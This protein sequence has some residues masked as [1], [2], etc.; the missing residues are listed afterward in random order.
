MS[1]LEQ[2][3]H[4]YN[5]PLVP[6]SLPNSSCSSV[7]ASSPLCRYNLGARRAVPPPTWTR[8][9]TRFLHLCLRSR[10]Q[11]RRNRL[12]SLPRYTLR[13]RSLSVLPMLLLLDIAYRRSRNA[14]TCSAVSCVAPARRRCLH[15][16]SGFKTWMADREVHCVN[17]L[18]V[19]LRAPHALVQYWLL[20]VSALQV[21]A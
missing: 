9:S 12:S 8:M 21:L 5:V 13:Q 4:A 20:W 2:L 10:R 19:P 1:L 7:P 6:I 11:H 17:R 14:I 3:S 15:A 16:V 18:Y